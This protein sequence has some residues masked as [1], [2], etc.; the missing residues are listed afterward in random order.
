[1]I[2]EGRRSRLL[3]TL[4]LAA[5]AFVAL[6]A[7]A[8][9]PQPFPS[10]DA[11]AEMLRTHVPTLADP[12]D[13]S[14][15]AVLVLNADN[16]F[17][18]AAAGR[19][20]VVVQ[21]WG[22]ALNSE[23]RRVRTAERK[24]MPLQ[25]TAGGG[26]RGSVVGGVARSG[27]GGAGGA[28]T[29][30]GR[31]GRSSASGGAGGGGG[32]VGGGLARTGGGGVRGGRGGGVGGTVAFRRSA[33]TVDSVTAWV[34]RGEG[35]PAF[36]SGGPSTAYAMGF[37]LEPVAVPG[38]A[39]RMGAFNAAPGLHALRGGSSDDSGIDGISASSLTS[40]ES[41]TF[42]PGTIGPRSLSVL[43]VTMK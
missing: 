33:F 16:N 20:N 8:R 39:T 4:P 18:K 22:D 37:T 2:R 24:G 1:M 15:Y 32:G 14:S 28:V 25:Q 29:G 9:S 13:S 42:A 19:G 35:A 3:A 31:G 30:G 41:F 6:T 43:V 40:M 11:I 5:I 21:V 17:V 36:S 7:A 38:E 10:S 27:G 12:T 26:G 34:P 23:A